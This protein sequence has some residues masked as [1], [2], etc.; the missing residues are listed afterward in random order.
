METNS[1]KT[2]GESSNTNP[3]PNAPVNN[4]DEGHGS[5]NPNDKSEEIPAGAD[6]KNT[7]EPE[8]PSNEDANPSGFMFL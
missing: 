1:T 4:S 2:V 6:G 3:N 7:D 5:K 8:T